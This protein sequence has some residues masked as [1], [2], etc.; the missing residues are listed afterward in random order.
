MLAD[1]LAD[2]VDADLL[3]VV[4]R[5]EAGESVSISLPLGEMTEIVSLRLSLI[6]TL[7]STSMATPNGF[8]CGWP[9]W[10]RPQLNVER[11]VGP[12]TD[13]VLRLS[14]PVND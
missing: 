11:P 8:I 13:R 14:T 7:P 9:S 12:A 6:Q 4:C 1:R 3:V 10:R 5:V 2:D